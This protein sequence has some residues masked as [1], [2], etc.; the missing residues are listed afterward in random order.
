MTSAFDEFVF[1]PE[2]EL[3]TL[4]SPIRDVA[5]NTD[6]GY[7]L[8]KVIEADDNRQ[9]DDE[10]RDMLKNDALN[11]WVEGLMEDPENKVV[12]YLDD[13]KTQWAISYITGG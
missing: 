9:I 7:W 13:E 10:N 8:I 5:T 3:E 6:G 12:S 1:D 11:K 2:V 4:S